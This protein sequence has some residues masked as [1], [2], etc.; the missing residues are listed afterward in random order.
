MP[1]SFYLDK[2]EMLQSSET[3]THLSEF[4]AS[5]T[6]HTVKLPLGVINSPQAVAKLQILHWRL[7]QST[8]VRFL[9]IDI[10]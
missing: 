9:V 1:Q 5:L 4:G 3:I 8:Q 6:T 10:V 2:W 7:L